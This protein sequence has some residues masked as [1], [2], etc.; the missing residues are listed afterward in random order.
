MVGSMAT[1]QHN[2]QAERQRENDETGYDETI[3]KANHFAAAKA[4]HVLIADR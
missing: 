4:K 2:R 3:N 1:E